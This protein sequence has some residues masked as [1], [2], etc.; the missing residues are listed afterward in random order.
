[1]KITSKLRGHEIIF[2]NDEWL[3]ADTMTP[4]VGNERDCGHCGKS[5]TKDGHD[6]CIGKLPNTM[7]ACCGHGAKNE[8]YIQDLNG[9]CIR[10]S[11]ALEKISI[12]SSE[13]NHT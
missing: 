12:L 3:Y 8:A 7:N 5:N 10:G 2:K 1:M 9:N 6:G 4:T 11:E 13:T